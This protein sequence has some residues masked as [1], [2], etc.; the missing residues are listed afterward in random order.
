[1]NSITILRQYISINLPEAECNRA[2]KYVAENSHTTE[3]QAEEFMAAY[4]LCFMIRKRSSKSGRSETDILTIS[5]RTSL[6]LEQAGTMYYFMKKYEIENKLS[7]NKFFL[8]IY[9]TLESF[10]RTYHIGGGKEIRQ[11]MPLDTTTLDSVTNEK[12]Y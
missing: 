8:K 6:S 7:S 11:K 4:D 1:M 5:H 10:L 9:P 3:A 12:N 2:I